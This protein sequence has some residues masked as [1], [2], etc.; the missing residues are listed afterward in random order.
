MSLVIFVVPDRDGLTVVVF[1]IVF[2]QE[3]SKNIGSV[4]KIFSI[5]FITKT[6]PLE[7]EEE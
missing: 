2:S 7:Q 6:P 3:A 4:N 1:R 5:K